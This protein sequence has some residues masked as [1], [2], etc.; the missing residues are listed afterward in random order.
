MC[1]PLTPLL[2][3]ATQ[4]TRTARTV[5]IR[6]PCKTP[7]A[8]YTY[9]PKPLLTTVYRR[10]RV[11]S[12]YTGKKESVS[13]KIRIL[14]FLATAYRT[15]CKIS[16]LIIGRLFFTSLSLVKPFFGEYFHPFR[17][18]NRCVTFPLYFKHL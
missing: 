18:S 16:R 12:V 5:K 6:V 3:P 1:R 4:K 9:T 17:H 15:H 7:P 2:S 14:F 11:T 10:N 8:T 13:V